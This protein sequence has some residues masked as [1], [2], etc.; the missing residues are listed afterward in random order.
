MS[1]KKGIFSNWGNQTRKE[2]QLLDEEK[3]ISGDS[4]N[5]TD[6][7]T[8]CQK[9]EQLQRKV[10]ATYDQELIVSLNESYQHIYNHL[11]VLDKIDAIVNE[12][13]KRQDSDGFQTTFKEHDDNVVRKSNSEITKDMFHD[14]LV[15]ENEESE[16]V[17]HVSAF[18]SMDKAKASKTHEQAAKVPAFTTMRIDEEDDDN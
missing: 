2:K 5:I 9:L 6:G 12:Q 18:T 3:S 14:R 8:F 10:N 1:R 11:A 15:F 4:N 16:H 13:S 7:I 17:E